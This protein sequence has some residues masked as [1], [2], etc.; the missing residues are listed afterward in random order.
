MGLEKGT[1]A[2]GLPSF[3][4]V[5]AKLPSDKP[6]TVIK[7][8]KVTSTTVDGTTYRI[9][10]VSENTLGK[11]IAVTGMVIVPHTAPPKGGYRVVAWGHGPTAWR[12]A[13]SLHSYTTTTCT[14]VPCPNQ[15]LANNWEIVGSDY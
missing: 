5:P 9:M 11:P 2:A 12:R 8:Q 6:G 13:P 1:P 15:L 7:H 10:Y 4:G 3:Y 14:T